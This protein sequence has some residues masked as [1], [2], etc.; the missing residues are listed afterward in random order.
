MLQVLH[1]AGGPMPASRVAN[2]A[3]FSVGS[4][5]VL[6]RTAERAGFTRAEATGGEGSPLGWSLTDAGRAWVAEH[7]VGVR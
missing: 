3:A 1:Q 2:A 4:I 5:R 7:S 6:L